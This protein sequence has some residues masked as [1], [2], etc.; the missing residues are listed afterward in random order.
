MPLGQCTFELKWH[1]G[2][3]GAIPSGHMGKLDLS[4]QP[5]SANTYS[6]R[7]Q[8]KLGGFATEV[9]PYAK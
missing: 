3:D 1:I 2:L 7:L 9:L 8:P 4:V 6:C 5:D